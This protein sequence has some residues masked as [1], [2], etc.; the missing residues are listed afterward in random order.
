M[1]NLLRIFLLFTPS[2]LQ[3]QVYFPYVHPTPFPKYFDVA[4]QFYKQYAGTSV[5]EIRIE[6]RRDG[7]VRRCSLDA[8]P[9]REVASWTAEYRRFWEDSFERLDALLD[10]LKS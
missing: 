8:R 3:A 10:E 6:K 9:L 5:P 1:N 2:L 4:M 7:R